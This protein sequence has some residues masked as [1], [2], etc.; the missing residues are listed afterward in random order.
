MERTDDGTRERR[1][2]RTKE[3]KEERSSAYMP[4]A[5]V[6]VAAVFLIA[7]VVDIGVQAGLSLSVSSKA[8]PAI[9]WY[10]MPS[11][12]DEKS[13]ASQPEKPKPV[14]EMS[15]ESVAELQV[16][17]TACSG[18]NKLLLCEFYAD[19][20]DPCKRMEETSLSNSQ[21][22]E[23]V[24]GNFVPVRI[25]DR[26]KEKGKNPRLVSDLQKKFRIFAF[27]TL[28]IVGADGEPVASLIGN[29]SSLTTYRFLSRSLHTV[30]KEAERRHAARYLYRSSGHS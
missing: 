7:R 28:V 14:Q 15:P 12:A 4:R 30:A 6:W 5:L 9:A 27:P 13:P 11:L 19:W 26:Q 25:T 16:M 1:D 29:C 21:I 3:P 8:K 17:T 18:Q 2:D 24:E 10:T 22:R 23:V 20:S